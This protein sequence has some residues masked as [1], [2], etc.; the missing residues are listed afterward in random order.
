MLRRGQLALRID[1]QI[2]R[3]ADRLTDNQTAKHTDGKQTNWQTDSQTNS[4]TDRQPARQ[5]DRSK[6]CGH[7]TCSMA[8]GACL[9]PKD[10]FYGH[11]NMLGGHRNM[12]NDHRACRLF[13]CS[14]DWGFFALCMSVCLSMCYAGTQ[15]WPSL[16]F[17]HYYGAAV[18]RKSCQCRM[19]HVFGNVFSIFKSNNRRSPPPTFPV[20]SRR[21]IAYD[22]PFTHPTRNVSFR[23]KL[24]GRGAAPSLSF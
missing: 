16:V 24:L 9:W 1:R 2:D 12:F 23:K 15:F 6:F 5:T 10:T 8:M 17:V 7:R 3:Q 21:H 13:W 20:V 19:R 22:D 4:Q 18:G 14:L 11:R